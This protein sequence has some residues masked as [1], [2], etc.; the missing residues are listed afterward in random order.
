[1]V[2]AAAISLENRDKNIELGMLNNKQKFNF[3][4]LAKG[5]FE[6]MEKAITTCNGYVLPKARERPW[7]PMLDKEGNIVLECFVLPL[8]FIKIIPFSTNKWG[9]IYTT[10][11]KFIVEV[12]GEEIGFSK[13]EFPTLDASYTGREI[14]LVRLYRAKVKGDK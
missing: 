6:M 2:E 14:A 10:I 4:K 3:E 5:A 7:E 12:L 11:N 8:G 13:V 9:E 1:M